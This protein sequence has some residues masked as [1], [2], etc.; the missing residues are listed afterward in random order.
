MLYKDK[1]KLLIIDGKNLTWRMSDA[2]SDLS[3]DKNGEDIATGGIHGFLTA[4]IRLRKKYNCKT[5]V[6]WEGKNN[7]RYKIFPSY[8]KRDEPTEEQLEL[9]N[10]VAGQ[11]KRIK[12]ILKYAGIKQY[13]AVK[14]EADDIMGTI[15][16]DWTKDG[17]RQAIIYTGDS[18]LRQCVS[19]YVLVLSPNR[20][21]AEVLYDV[22][23]VYKKD[24]VWPKY[25]SDLKALAGD[26]S[27]KI[28]GVLGI[29]PKTAVALISQYG[30]VNKI[31]KAAKKDLDN[32]PVSERFKPLIVDDRNMILKYKKL[33]TIL[34]NAEKKYIKPKKDKIK[35]LKHLKFY[36]LASVMVPNELKYLMS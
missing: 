10:E 14:C 1:E 8:K 29:G 7:F 35:L 18:D 34:L 33:T 26:S 11:E 5:V 2:F 16:G 24:G 32:W 3:V 23:S 15:A 6:C 28:P 31:I 21:G 9:I 25:V 13:K 22:D 4:L 19:D 27:D 12:V 17:T 20:K 30:T 36:R